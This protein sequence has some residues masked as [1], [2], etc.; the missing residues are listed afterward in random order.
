[1][2]IGLSIGFMSN[3]VNNINSIF[4]N[5]TV[6]ESKSSNRISYVNSEKSYSWTCPNCGGHSYHI[7]EHIGYDENGSII[8]GSKYRVCDNCGYK[9]EIGVG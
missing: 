4:K 2:V 5:G 7:E 3:N 8:G 1:M 9:E 6:Q